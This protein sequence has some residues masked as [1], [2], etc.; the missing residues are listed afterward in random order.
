[1]TLVDT[2]VISILGTAELAAL[3]AMSVII[4]IMQMS[5]QT[6]NVSN[7]TLVANAIGEKNNDK[8]KLITGNSII[9][10]ILISIITITVICIVQPVF[11]T[12][13]QVDKIC[14]SYLSIRLLGFIQSSIVTVLSGHQRTIGNQGIILNLRIFAVVLNLILDLVAV[15]L[16]YGVKGVAWATIFIDTILSIYLLN[17]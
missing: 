11:P 1:M 4:N 12:L 13:F 10:T 16:G 8:V 5:I 14:I 2:L 9:M 15:K 7:I 6:I 17:K 3:G